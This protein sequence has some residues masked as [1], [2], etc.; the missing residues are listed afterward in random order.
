MFFVIEKNIITTNKHGKLQKNTLQK[1][2]CLSWLNDE[3]YFI[4]L[5]LEELVSSTL[6]ENNVDVLYKANLVGFKCLFFS[7]LVMLLLDKRDGNHI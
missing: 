3:E 2:K 4:L 7:K 6:L 1:E 5:E